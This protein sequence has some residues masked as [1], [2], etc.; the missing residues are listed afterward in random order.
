MSQADNIEPTGRMPNSLI[1]AMLAICVSPFL[2]NLVGVDF[3]SSKPGFPWADASSMAPHEKIDAMFHTLSGSFTHTLLEWTAFLTAIFT[4]FLAF[5]HFSINKDVTT[6]IIGVA[7]FCAGVMDAFHTLAADRLIESVADNRNLIP[8]TW[9][10]SRIFNALI[11]I[12]GVGLFMFK[13]IRTLKGDLRFVLGI[14][15]VFLVLAYTIISYCANSASLPQTMYPDSLITRPYDVAPL[16]LFAIAGLTL[17]RWFYAQ[18]PGIFT[19]ALLLAMVPEV[20]VELHMAFGSTALFDNHF[21]IAHFI[22]ILAYLVPFLGLALDYRWTYQKLEREMANREK[23]EAAQAESEA[24]TGAIVEMALEG[25]IT[26]D[27]QGIIESFNASAE[28]KFRYRAAEVQGRNI[29]ILMVGSFHDEQGRDAAYYEDMSQVEFIGDRRETMGKRKGGETF[30]MEISL[31]EVT[32]QNQR[33]FTWFVRDISDRKAAEVERDALNKQLIETSRRVGMADVATGVLHNVGNV[34]NSVNVAAGVVADTVRRSSVDKISR[35]A[36]MIQEHLH[37]VGN[38]L[39]Q[40]PKGQQIPE[41]LNKLG[42]QLT[43]DQ[44]VV[45]K[46]L[47]ELTKNIEHIKEIISVQQTVAKSSAWEEP[48]VLEELMHQAL[49][50]SQAS[51]DKYQIEIISEYMPVPEIVVDKHQ[52]LQILVNLISNSKHAMKHVSD[53]PRVLTVRIVQFEEHETDWV[54]LEVSDTGMGIP[55]EN[56]TRIFSQG[57]TTKKDGHGFGLHSGSLSAKL[58]GGSLTVHSDGE[59]QGATFTLTLPAKRREVGVA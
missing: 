24:R 16:I 2:L 33:M 5:L 15:G 32:L 54:K 20:V 3:G 41:Y 17:F 38:Y 52:V 18:Q 12:I 48:V 26:T 34:L 1:W 29:S 14:S 47:K 59:H 39:T 9:A 10:I 27:E 25:I 46:E 6:P 40:D 44:E 21:N 50:V 19:H 4:L 13:G 23:A 45:I 58:M 30:H 49:A 35:T 42:Q 37:D 28:R 53:R 43:Q 57:F 56:M 31:I 51:L 11:L 55:P 8:F 7:L 22:K 36:G